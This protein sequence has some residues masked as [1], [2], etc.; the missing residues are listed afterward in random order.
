MTYVI[1][2]VDTT[3]KHTVTH[4]TKIHSKNQALHII[5]IS[6]ELHCIGAITLVC[7]KHVVVQKQSLCSIFL[8]LFFKYL[9]PF[10]H[11]IDIL[12][13]YYQ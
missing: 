12:P 10:F 5:C 11:I 6:S 1:Q 8:V 4:N 2:I 3:V 13:L 9:T 7:T